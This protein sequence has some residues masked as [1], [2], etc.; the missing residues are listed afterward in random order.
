MKFISVLLALSMLAVP[1]FGTTG[2]RCDVI[3]EQ[4]PE[5]ADLKNSIPM[6]VE[7]WR[8][9]SS[10]RLRSSL[11]TES[12]R[13]SQSAVARS[14]QMDVSTFSKYANN[15]LPMNWNHAV[16]F[17]EALGVDPLWLIGQDLLLAYN[18]TRHEL[19]PVDIKA[20]AP[21]HFV[22]TATD[23]L[24]RSS[25]AESGQPPIADIEADQFCLETCPTPDLLRELADR[26]WDISHVR[27][28]HPPEKPKTPMQVFLE[29]V[30]TYSQKRSELYTRA[31]EGVRFGYT[32]DPIGATERYFQDYF[33]PAL[34]LIS[35]APNSEELRLRMYNTNEIR[36]RDDHQAHARIVSFNIRIRPTRFARKD[37]FQDEFQAFTQSFMSEL[38]AS[39]LSFIREH[40][41]SNAI[42]INQEFGDSFNRL[43]LLP[44]QSDQ[45]DQFDLLVVRYS[46]VERGVVSASLLTHPEI[47]AAQSRGSLRDQLLGL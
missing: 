39:N 2:S 30:P 12:G 36:F 3:L 37:E 23:V 8:E 4:I 42:E 32:K 45:H 26:G 17:G 27:L 47:L 1:S 29:Q 35:S 6:L 11:S 7:R 9:L 16:K 28:I 24:T 21:S 18:S 20:F 13:L 38:C 41:S 33:E 46:T 5:T 14:I 31:A 34:R 43:V 10:S 40:F 19:N 25:N 15:K 22:R 44:L